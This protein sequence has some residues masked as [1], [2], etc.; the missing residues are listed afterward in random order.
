MKQVA[1][2]SASPSTGA[3]RSHADGRE[4]PAVDVAA[5]DE[6]QFSQD[7]A[8]MLKSGLTL[9]DSLKTLRE[10]AE[11]RRG[12]TLDRLMRLLR[13][14]DSL[15][16]A[17]TACGGFKPGLLACVRSS[18]LTGDLSESLQRYAQ[19]ATRLRKM[20]AQMVSALVYPVLLI[21]VASLVVLFLLMYVVPRFATILEGSGH[22][23]PAMSRLLIAVGRS[24][25][26]VPVAGWVA[27]AV[28]VAFAVWQLVL[29]ARAGKL[30]S[31]LSEWATHVPGIR[32]LV[33]TFSHAQLARSSGMLVASGV[34]VLKALAMCRELLLAQDRTR[35]DRALASA[36][37]GSPLAAALH[38]NG[39]I[40][41]LGLRVLKVSEQ[42]G[43]I[44]AAL[45]R[46]ADIH[47]QHV[48]RAL[49]RAG[50]LIEPVLMLGI[51]LVV[52]GI[53]VLMYLP[54]F[55]LAASVG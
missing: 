17:M 35:L 2:Q 23:L 54:I 46:L 15:S 3:A 25:G 6:E 53:V 37:S 14:G 55:Q 41:T 36:S 26:A 16:V 47:D 21:S 27:L 38:D 43:Q 8:L 49:E 18:E 12:R 9:L 5:I 11:P 32:E 1:L 22:D 52:G 34:P 48:E 33:I 4:A 7:I 30:E 45:D 19:N 31:L 51:G 44:H 50:R 28:L 39:L 24:L 13:E 40:D 20:R 10:R 29:A 42:T